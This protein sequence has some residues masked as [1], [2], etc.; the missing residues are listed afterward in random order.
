MY[1]STF[2]LLPGRRLVTESQVSWYGGKQ[3][4]ANLKC[5]LSVGYRPAFVIRLQPVNTCIAGISLN[6]K[7]VFTFG[8]KKIVV[9]EFSLSKRDFWSWFHAIPYL[10]IYH[11][12]VKYRHFLSL[13]MKIW[14]KSWNVDSLSWNY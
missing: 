4:L 13:N 11:R 9:G 14:T 2:V 8:L 7:Q 12:K 10:H 5:D 1:L 3:R 6:K